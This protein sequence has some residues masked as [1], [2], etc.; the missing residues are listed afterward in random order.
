MK[1]WMAGIAL[2]SLAMGMA[3]QAQDDGPFAMQIKARQ[4]LMNY[5]AINVGTL[6][7]MA[8]GEAEY[9]AATAK[10]AA[11]ALLASATF[12]M[13]MLWPAGSDNAA[14]PKSTA[15]A[16]IWAEGSKIGEDSATFLAATQAMAAGAGTDLASL[17][18]A[19][20]ALGGSCG[21]CHKAF[22]VPTN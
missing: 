6:A 17:Q 19:M 10:T 16:A 12:D 4:G 5:R 9:D 11:D 1:K 14:N 7:A 20:G 18:A 21:S 13:S 22:R 3:A 2:V 15:S 8:K